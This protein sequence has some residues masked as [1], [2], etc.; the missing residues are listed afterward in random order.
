M[1]VLERAARAR[2]AATKISSVKDFADTRTS[3]ADTVDSSS[4]VE[5]ITK[6]EGS[7]GG[8]NDNSDKACNIVAI[9]GNGGMG[10]SSLV[11]N[12]LVEARRRGYFASAKFDQSHKS[13]FAPV[14]R[15]INSIFEQVLTES[16]EI[17]GDFYHSV[18]N[19][20]QRQAL[21][22]HKMKIDLPA[23]EY[24]LN[25]APQASPGPVKES[26]PEPTKA[27]IVKRG[28]ST[29][30]PPALKSE[31]QKTP[32]MK[33]TAVSLD[34]LRILAKR[35]F[36]CLWL[37]D[38]Q[39]AD[40]ESLQLLS[41]IVAANI[42]ITLILTYRPGEILAEKLEGILDPERANVTT[43]KLGPLSEE[44]VIEYV[45]LTLYR[46]ADNI[47]P[48]VAVVQAKAGG[49]PF[50]MREMLNMLH[51]KGCITFSRSTLT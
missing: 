24:I 11:T 29:R 31:T 43:I 15:V 44:D 16:E 26:S 17:V 38:L 12:V 51:R 13:P 4:A 40:D 14:L 34:V 1:R 22:L 28:L 35:K 33:F 30:M 6:D 7:A 25:A 48:L 5:V 32:E 8:A 3:R 41:A 37:D 2:K 46:P 42:Q 39:F 27:L 50:Y 36:V 19:A 45:S 47:I 49:N 21:P 20:F 18:C 23:L 9:V 10:K